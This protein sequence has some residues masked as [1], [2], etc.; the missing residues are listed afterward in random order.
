MSRTLYWAA[1]VLVM[2]V[3]TYLPRAL[4]LTHLRRPVKSR[5]L[6][7]FLYYMPFAVLGAMT[8]PAI[9]YAT[10]TPWSALAGFAVALLLSWFGL[11]LLPVALASTAMVFAVEWAMRLGG[12]LP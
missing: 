10:A 12:L 11:S 4:P 3:V 1:A 6:R 9:L 5:F 7:S 2:A 8:F